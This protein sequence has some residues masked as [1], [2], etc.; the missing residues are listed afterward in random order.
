[1]SEK[2]APRA[3]L[4]RALEADLVGPFRRGLPGPDGKPSDGMETVE[5]SSSRPRAGT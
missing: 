3:H 5:E 2:T 4:V 1:M